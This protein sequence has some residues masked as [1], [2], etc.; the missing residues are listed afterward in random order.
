LEWYY[1]IIHY[2]LAKSG[3]AFPSDNLSDGQ[4]RIKLQNMV[5]GIM[6][7]QHVK[8]TAD[9][10]CT[11]SSTM[12]TYY[13]YTT[14]LLSA[15]SVY[16]HSKPQRRHV[17]LHDF[18]HDEAGSDDY[19]YHSDDAMFN[20]D[21]TDSSI[22]AYVTILCPNSGLKSTSTKV[23]MPSKKWFSISDSNKVIWDRLEDQAKAIMF[24]Y[25]S[26]TNTSYSSW[27]PF[28]KPPLS[29]GSLVKLDLQNLLL[30]HKQ[31]P[32]KSPLMI[33]Y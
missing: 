17:M 10:M 4:K 21:C 30:V 14:L 27:P 18:Q 13:E 15:A 31:N 19:H 11:T 9:Q 8:N 20:I 12:L 7:L 24:G 23:Q 26:L 2:Q 25:V 32:M 22:Q 33:F 5:N 29:S 6:D 3:L 1:Q 16:G 28:P